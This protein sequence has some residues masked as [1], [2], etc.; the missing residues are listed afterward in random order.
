M[1]CD[2]KLFKAQVCDLIASFSTVN[3]YKTSSTSPPSALNA[4]TSIP[5]VMK[6]V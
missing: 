6:A 3:Y 1:K 4:C 5:K 2:T